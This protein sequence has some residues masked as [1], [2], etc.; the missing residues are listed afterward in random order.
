MIPQAS[1]L[2]L[3]KDEYMTLRGYTRDSDSVNHYLRGQWTLPMSTKDVKKAKNMARCIRNIFLRV[4][5]L[6]GYVTLW[7]G[8]N[9]DI[10]KIKVGRE[11]KFFSKGMVSTSKS[12]RVAMGFLENYCCI[13]KLILPPY[14]KALFIG[15][16]SVYPQEEEVLIPH[17]SR[18][19]IK[20]IKGGEIIAELK[21]QKI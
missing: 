6:D 16:V 5:P 7:R 4:P 12:K 2:K 11:L 21:S 13:F 9:L 8:A 17:N 18:F 15:D 20:S 19:I 3:K 10:K 1:R 14:S